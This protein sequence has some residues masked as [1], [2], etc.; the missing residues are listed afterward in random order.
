[1]RTNIFLE[2]IFYNE[3]QI[4]FASNPTAALKYLL[5]FITMY[6]NNFSD[7]YYEKLKEKKTISMSFEKAELISYQF[8]F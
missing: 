2:F 3:V 5:F 7:I 1:M 6:H 4:S 8:V